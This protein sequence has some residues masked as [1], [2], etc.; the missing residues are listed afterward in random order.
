[1]ISQKALR[2]TLAGDDAIQQSGQATQESFTNGY[3]GEAILLGGI[4][5]Q[6]LQISLP[7]KVIGDTPREMQARIGMDMVSID[8]IQEPIS[9]SKGGAR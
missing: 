5:Y 9:I 1:V 7:L 6:S 2:V 4:D 3:M 8:C